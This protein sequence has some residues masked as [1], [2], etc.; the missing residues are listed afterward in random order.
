MIAFESW[1]QAIVDRH[2]DE[3]VRGLIDS[4]GCRPINRFSHDACRGAR[5][6]AACAR[7]VLSNPRADIRGLFCAAGRRPRPCWTLSGA[8]NAS[9]ARRASVARLDAPG[10]AKR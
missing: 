3:L 10:C 7:Y 4:D 9:V 5:R 6:G 8:R 2:P 1:Q